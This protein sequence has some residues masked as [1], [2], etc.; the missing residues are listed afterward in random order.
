MKAIQLRDEIIEKHANEQI[1]LSEGELESLKK[2][3]GSESWAKKFVKDQG[4]KS[5]A[6]KEDIDTLIAELRVLASRLENLEGFNICAG[7]V[8]D[9][10]NSSA[11]TWRKLERDRM[12]RSKTGQ[13]CKLECSHED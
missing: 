6:S 9:A 11:M 3:T 12:V 2:F 1:E 8:R 13:E 5:K 4:W 10:A 7:K